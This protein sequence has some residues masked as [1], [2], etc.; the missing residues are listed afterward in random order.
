MCGRG[1]DWLCGKGSGYDWLRGIGRD[2]PECG[3]GGR[4]KGRARQLALVLVLIQP[5]TFYWLIGSYSML[6][7]RNKIKTF[8]FLSTYIFFYS[9]MTYLMNS[10]ISSSVIHNFCEKKSY[11]LIKRIR[12]SL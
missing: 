11:G 6:T 3:R 10:H 1:C 12:M 8:Y 2:W 4:L 5:R 9:Y 7:I